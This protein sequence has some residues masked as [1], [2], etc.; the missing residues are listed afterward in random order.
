MPSTDADRVQTAFDAA[1]AGDVEALVS[2]FDPGLE[3]RGVS[4]GHLWWRH[5]PS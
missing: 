3:W 2:I 5:T 4:R 1:L